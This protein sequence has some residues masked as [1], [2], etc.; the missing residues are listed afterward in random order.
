MKIQQYK[1]QTQMAKCAQ[2]LN[3]PQFSVFNSCF[4]IRVSLDEKYEA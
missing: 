4:A 2:E 3:Q 1:P